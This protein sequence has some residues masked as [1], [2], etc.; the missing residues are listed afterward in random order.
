MPTLAEFL[1]SRIAEDEAAIT[2]SFNAGDTMTLDEH[3]MWRDCHAKR[4]IVWLHSVTDAKPS[5]FEFDCGHCD[6]PWP[7]PTLRLLALPYTDHAEFDERW[8]P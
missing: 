2:Q 8:R 3:Q 5:R 7:C 6:M 4:Q 1:L